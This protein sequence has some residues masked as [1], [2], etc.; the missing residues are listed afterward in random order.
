[1]AWSCWRGYSRWPR[2]AIPRDMD[3]WII[4][5]NIFCSSALVPRKGHKRQRPCV[6]YS[7]RSCVPSD[8]ALGTPNM[9]P[10]VRWS[11]CG[12]AGRLGLLCQQPDI[13]VP[14]GLLRGK[15]RTLSA[16]PAEQTGQARAAPPQPVAR[17]I[18]AG[19][20]VSASH[21]LEREGREGNQIVQCRSARPMRQRLQRWMPVA[22]LWPASPTG[23]GKRRGSAVVEVVYFRRRQTRTAKRSAGCQ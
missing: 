2:S 5:L 18:V 12:T 15:W 20:T 6:Q 23:G 9:D 13:P 14:N 3:C 10:A 16:G 19:Q 22:V 4:Q 7:F 8:T 17:D 11:C 21:D 1:M